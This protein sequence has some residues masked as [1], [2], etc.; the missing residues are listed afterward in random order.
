M[1]TAKI[2]DCTLRDGAYLVN[3][4]FGQENIRG[5][6]NGLVKARI[7]YIEVGFFQDDDFG[8]GKTVFRNSEDVSKYIP[9]DKKGC[10]FTVLADYSRY[11][12]EN[13]DNRREDSIDGVRECFF[14]NERFE[15][16]KACSI[17]KEKG[18]KLFVQPVDIL[19]YSDI[20]LIEFIQEVNKIEPYCFSIVDTFG[21]M[22]QEDLVHYFELIDH[23][24]VSTCKIGFHSH[25]NMQMSNALSQDFIKMA[26]GRREVIIDGTISG[27][28]RGAGNTPL[29]LI[30]QYMVNRMGLHYNI[31][32]L[33]DIIDNYMDNIKTRCNWGYNTA[34]F[35]AGCYGAHVNNVQYL[36][37]KASIQSKDIRFIL[38]EIGE[39]S[40]KRY[41]YDLL[42]KTYLNYITSK[43]NDDDNL[44]TLNDIFGGKN[45]LI[46]A[47]GRTAKE[48]EEDIISYLD[49]KPSKVITINFLHDKV[50][51][52]FV[53]MSN[54]K[55][56]NSFI[57][58]SEF[59]SCKKILTSNIKQKADNNNEIIISF[60]RL[61]KC[62]W[63]HMDNSTI[64]LLRLLDMFNGIKSISIA[65]FD[66]YSSFVNENKNYSS[67]YLEKKMADEESIKI[68]REIVGMLEDFK[69]TRKHKDVPINFITESRF[70]YIFE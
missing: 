46:I 20:E 10:K 45:V 15:A 7:D 63:E 24:L 25:N 33:L 32:A 40:R 69:A 11:T 66:G 3:K 34:Y 17:I 1:K 65:G 48:N 47:P 54:V 12:I 19:G 23:N 44:N 35:I 52:D 21:S 67:R 64:L 28:G 53:Y 39:V 5:I 49:A 14:K 62:G 9:K 2:L 22:Y 18:Y 60:S 58:N 51:S 56:Y 68:N 59:D 50:K 37:D 70:A 41:D 4:E 38:N 30:V 43:I 13:L 16:L 31:D 55:R 29:E 26:S 6:I 8:E 61:I 27:M 57:N 42:E 36:L